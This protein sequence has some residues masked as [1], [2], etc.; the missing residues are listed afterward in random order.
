MNR[1]DWMFQKIKRSRLT[2][3]TF[4]DEGNELIEMKTMN[5]YDDSEEI[6]QNIYCDF[7]DSYFQNENSFQVKFIYKESQIYYS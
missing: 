3:D 7:C 4:F 6:N 2:T 1:F 5:I